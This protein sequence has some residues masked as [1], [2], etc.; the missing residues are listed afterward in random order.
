MIHLFVSFISKFWGENLKIYLRYSTLIVSFF[1]YQG[2][3]EWALLNTMSPCVKQNFLLFSD[4]SKFSVNQD[5]EY[6]QI[7]AQAQKFFI[8]FL[9]TYLNSKISAKKLFFWLK[10][11]AVWENLIYM[12]KHQLK[13]KI[14]SEIYICNLFSI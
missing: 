10:G 12:T 2:F 7:T 5:K 4:S 13:T 8:R 6:T 9:R 3:P 14:Q 11:S 1:L